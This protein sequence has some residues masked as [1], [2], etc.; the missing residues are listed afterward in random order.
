MEVEVNPGAVRGRTKENGIAKI[1]INTQGGSSTLQ[2]TV[3]SELEWK[4]LLTFEIL[5]TC[6]II[7]YFQAKT[8]DPK[9]N[10]DQ[11]A[12]RKMTALPYVPKGG[13]NNYLHIGIDG[14]EL[15]I[16]D[17]IKV[18]LN[19]GNSPGVTK[20]D[21]TYMVRITC[22]N[23]CSNTTLYVLDVWY[24]LNVLHPFRDELCKLY[25]YM[26]MLCKKKKK[27]KFNL[28]SCWSVSDLAVT[29]FNTIYNFLCN[30]LNI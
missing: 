29:L 13:S 30:R 7:V 14:V 12:V 5:Q 4:I 2:I 15:Q 11:Q 23:W 19:L 27:K 20:Q 16:G 17:Q 1:T 18:N 24:Q 21:F 25:T 6:K 28:H 10:D 26:C 3:R 9:L 22:C 8:K